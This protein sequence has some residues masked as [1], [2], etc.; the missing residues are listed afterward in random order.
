MEIWDSL[1]TGNGQPF[2]FQIITGKFEKI[3]GIFCTVKAH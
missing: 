3:A 1:R 2:C